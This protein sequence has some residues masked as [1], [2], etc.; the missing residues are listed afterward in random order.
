MEHSPSLALSKLHELGIKHGDI[1]KHNFLIRDGEVTVVDFDMAVKV[2]DVKELEHEMENL[3][4]QL[5]DTSGRGGRVV[6]HG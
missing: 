2:G 5:M 4:G 6:E 1:N 3:R